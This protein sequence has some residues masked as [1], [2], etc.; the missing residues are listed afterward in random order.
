LAEIALQEAQ[1]TLSQVRLTRDSEGNFNY[2]YTADE[3]KI[4]EA[5][6][7]FADAENKLYNIRLEGANDFKEQYVTLLQE[8]LE[9][10]IEVQTDETLTTEVKNE[11]I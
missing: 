4:M 2:V 11:R 6:Q 3:N 7:K 1:N 10:I 8:A 5:Q 9:K